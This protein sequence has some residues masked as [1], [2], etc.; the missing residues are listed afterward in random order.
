LT[1]RYNL[2]FDDKSFNKANMA[3]RQLG[4]AALTLG[5]IL[6]AAVVGRGFA[7]MIGLASDAEETINLLNESFEGNSQAV[8]EWAATFA[9]EVGRSE[10]QMREMA[11]TL[12]AMLNPLM[13][14]NSDA[15][16]EMSTKLA[17]LAVDLGSFFNIA[18][19]DA[20]QKLMAGIAGE[21][22][23][24]RRLGVVILESTLAEFARAEGIRKSV[25]DM[26]VAEK[27][28][29]RYQFILANTTNAQGDALRTAEGF[30]NASKA[31]S[32]GLRDLATRMGLI[33]LPAITRL[34]TGFR[35]LV[36]AFVDMSRKSN[37]I[38]ALFVVLGAAAVALGVKL[39][40]AF[41]G[42]LLVFAKWFL[43][44]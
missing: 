5:S 11:G 7:K 43:I 38:Q 23:P 25:K 39:A 4:A 16:A 21:T 3:M 19:D 27:T 41:A 18:D 10:F 2:F 29:L 36:R 31:V 33:L 20:L 32:T 26:T 14:G 22:E 35:D 6:G 12:G 44:S 37:I 8:Q 24:L 13:A 15:A 9:S 40:I 1:A 28:S 17:A 34:T 42:P 30:A